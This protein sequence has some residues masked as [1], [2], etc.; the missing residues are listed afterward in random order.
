[1]HA[2]YYNAPDLGLCVCLVIKLAPCRESVQDTPCQLR[3]WA[4]MFL[5]GY[6]SPSCLAA[7]ER[8]SSVHSLQADMPFLGAVCGSPYNILFSS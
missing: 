2:S 7:E 1:M 4:G 6:R 5:E 8:D 3:D